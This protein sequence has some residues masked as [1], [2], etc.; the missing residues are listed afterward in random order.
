MHARYYFYISVLKRGL[1]VEYNMHYTILNDRPHPPA[2]HHGLLPPTQQERNRA[3]RVAG[4]CGTMFQFNLAH[5]TSD[6]NYP[7]KEIPL[8]LPPCGQRSNEITEV[9]P[10][11]CMA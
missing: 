11:T 5:P 1:S 8:S 2:T 9:W 3:T 6:L 7:E 10:H 4:W